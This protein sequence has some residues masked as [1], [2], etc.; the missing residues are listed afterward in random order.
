MENIGQLLKDKR[1]ELKKSFDEIH[2]QTRIAVEHLQ[3]LEENN[4][5]FLPETYIKSFLR[6]YANALGLSADDLVKKHNTNQKTERAE[7]EKEIEIQEQNAQAAQ[8]LNRLLEWALAAGAF[9]VLVFIL[10]VYLQYRSEIYARPIEHNNGY[11]KKATFKPGNPAL[12]AMAAPAVV[13]TKSFQLHMAGLEDL[14]IQLDV[15]GIHLNESDDQ[16]RPGASTITAVERFDIVIDEAKGMRL[17]FDDMEM[18]SLGAAGGKV[19][20]SIVRAAGSR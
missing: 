7:E 18:A 20:L 19:R 15:T 2:A 5:S 9:L 1:T 4:F 14:A 10:L 11:L 13:T 6:T 3:F 8:P 16:A 17:K 12:P